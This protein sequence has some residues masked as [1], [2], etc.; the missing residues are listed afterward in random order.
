MS[1]S[2]N[3]SLSQ[4]VTQLHGFPLD[5][6]E[7]RDETSVNDGLAERTGIRKGDNAKYVELR[8][9]VTRLHN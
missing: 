8:H 1:P 6:T 5:M 7:K 2:L 4:A 3:Q 9:R